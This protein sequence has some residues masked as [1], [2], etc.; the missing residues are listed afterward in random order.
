MS[1]ARQR[2]AVRVPMR[3]KPTIR[4]RLLREIDRHLLPAV[5]PAVVAHRRVLE[6]HLLGER[7][8]HEDRVL[9]DRDRVRR[10][11]HHQRDAARGERRDLDRVVADADAC[12][13]AQPRRHGDFRRLQRRQRQRDAVGVAQRRLQVRHRDVGLVGDRID[14]VAADQ[15][16]PAGLRHGVRAASLSSCSA[17]WVTLLDGR[18][19]PGPPRGPLTRKVDTGQTAGADNPAHPHG[20]SSATSD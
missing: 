2:F 14:V 10:A 7:V 3:P 12:R 4:M 16:V 20:G 6:H 9:G 8:H 11:D 15:H 1:I 5:L 17:S 13:D 19:R 18:A